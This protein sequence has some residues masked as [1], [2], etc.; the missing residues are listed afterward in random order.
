[1]I[2]IAHIEELSAED[3]AVISQFTA[4]LPAT[5]IDYRPDSYPFKYIPTGR[6]DLF[7]LGWLV[8]T[9][10]GAGAALLLTSFFK[11]IGTEL[12]KRLVDHWFKHREDK[13]TL[14]GPTAIFP[15]V[16]IYEAQPGFLV[17]VPL[18]SSTQAGFGE[19][20]IIQELADKA[21]S[22]ST[23]PAQLI[24]QFDADSGRWTLDPFEFEYLSRKRNDRQV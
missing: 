7:Q 20:P 9:F 22:D 3:A 4:K 6:G 11:A 21:C 17:V 1:M 23:G 16:V 8:F 12:G 19:M 13:R 15:C 24:A 5:K 10:A 14:L 18:R 2:H